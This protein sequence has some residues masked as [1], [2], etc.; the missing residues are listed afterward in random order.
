MMVMNE[1]SY[2]PAVSN[3]QTH[4]HTHTTHTHTTHTHKQVVIYRS[5]AI[6]EKGV[7][8]DTWDDSTE[9]M[10][11]LSNFCVHKRG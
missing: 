2:H 5:D 4:M 1:G 6:V 3:V 11:T 8:F 9:L 7:H 10:C